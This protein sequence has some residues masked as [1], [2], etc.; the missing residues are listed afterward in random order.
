MHSRAASIVGLIDTGGILAI[1]DSR[2]RWHS[3]CLEALQSFRL[4][5]LTT[6]AILTETFRL[7]GR[8]PHN[9]EKTWRFVRSGA[10]TIHP[11]QDAHLQELHALM[12]QYSDRLMDFADATLVH[13]AAR[14]R[15][16]AILTVDHDDFETYRLPGG[17]SSLSFP[18]EANRE[19]RL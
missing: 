9:V 8:N 2:D 5:L 3:L 10:L 16:N 1:V 4:P 11:M 14:E 17:R 6:E 13:L 19:T 7:T 12:S 15:V 18:G